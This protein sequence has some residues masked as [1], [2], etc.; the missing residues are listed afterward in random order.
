MGF[1]A[2]QVMPRFINPLWRNI[3]GSNVWGYA[4]VSAA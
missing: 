1:Y 3:A 2:R 4:A